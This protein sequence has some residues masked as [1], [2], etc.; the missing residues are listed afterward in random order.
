MNTGR[1]RLPLPHIVLPVLASLLMAAAPA[2]E[3]R[4]EPLRDAI[5]T[6]ARATNPA[7]IAFDRTTTAV[8]RGPGIKDKTV[9]VER[10]DGQHWSLVSVNGKPPTASQ[11][12]DFR[13]A[14]AANPVPG[15]YRLAAL[16][17][18]A[19]DISTDG[20]GRK[21]LKIPVLPP[22]TVRTDTSDISSHLSG[23]AVLASNDGKPYVARLKVKAHENFKLNLLI[24]VTNFEQISDY[25]LGPDGRPR[26]ASQTADS[27]GSMFGFVGGETNEVTYAYR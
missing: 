21:V 12:K 20:D 1:T 3:L 18:A 17:A 9:T 26:L 15:Y 13:K 23:E 22:G 6:D 24:K 2:D 16:M 4:L 5:I 14:T 7:T 11:L 19:S 10:W 8:R 27:K 25:R